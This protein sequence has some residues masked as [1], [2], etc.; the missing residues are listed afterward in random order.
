METAKWFMS[1][2]AQEQWSNVMGFSSPNSRAQIDNPVAQNVAG[3]ISASN[4]VALQRYWEATPPDIVET[5]VDE[6]SRFILDPSTMD[7]V[8][9]N[10]QAKA[11]TVWAE[12]Q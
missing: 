9:A 5:A 10:I 2:S 12:R 6:L 7:E 8:L 1:T 3:Q 11:E 4:A